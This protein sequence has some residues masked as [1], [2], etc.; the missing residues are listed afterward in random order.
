MDPFEQF[1]LIKEQISQRSK[2][3]FYYDNATKEIISIRRKYDSESEYPFIEIFHDD[4]IISDPLNINSIEY[5]IVENDGK[6]ILS[7]RKQDLD[8]V[9]KIDE[10]VFLIPREYATPDIVISQ[11]NYR[12]D[13]LIEQDNQKREFRIRFSGEIKDQYDFKRS[14]NQSIFLYVT[15]ENDSTILYQTLS[16]MISDLLKHK[17]VTIPFDGEIDSCNIFSIKHFQRYL[18]LVIE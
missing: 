10:K 13:M 3:Y 7:K 16:P 9:G 11:V 6:I 5:Q 8:L 12:Y 2:L 15:Q 18:H 14:S 1:E 4:P 17:F